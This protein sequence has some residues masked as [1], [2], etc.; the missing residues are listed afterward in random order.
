MLMKRLRINNMKNI[1]KLIEN[2]GWLPIEEV[3]THLEG[4][5][6]FYEILVSPIVGNQ[7][8]DETNFLYAYQLREDKYAYRHF[9]YFMPPETPKLMAAVIRYLANEML[10]ITKETELSFGQ[11]QHTKAACKAIDALRKA[12]KIAGGEDV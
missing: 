1:E 5:G 10:S 8:F 2:E 11:E 9:R 3:Y 4:K 7:K 6:E 12:N